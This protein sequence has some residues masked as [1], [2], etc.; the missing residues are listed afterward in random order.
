MG[1]R[2]QQHERRQRN[3]ERWQRRQQDM[4]DLWQ[5][6]THCSFVSNPY[7]AIDNEQELQA[8]CL[9]GESEHD[10]W[11]EVISRRDKQKLKP[12]MSH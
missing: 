5:R 11:H 8:W 7:L 1:R 3:R 2:G 4:L 6:R 9:L 10:H 12:R